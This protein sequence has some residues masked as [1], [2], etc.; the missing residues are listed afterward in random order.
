MSLAWQYLLIFLGVAVEGP[1]V[2]LTAAALAGNGLLNPWLVFLTAG[3]GNVVGDMFWYTLGYH[4]GFERRLRAWSFVAR[5]AS[6]IEQIK[7]EVNQ[8]APQL[9][10]GAKLSLGIGSIPTLIA[11]G[12]ARV[13]WWRV[14]LV[15][16]AGEIIWTGSLVLI[17]FF[18]GQYVPQILKDMRIATIVGGIIFLLLVLGLWR[19]PCYTSTKPNCKKKDV[20]N[21]NSADRTGIL[22][23]R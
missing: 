9:L 16:S 19:R 7:L 18:L 11:A 21:E 2:T 8:R 4:G 5:Y 17:G 15:Q 22:S 13:R 6:Q 20:G 12:M 10:L 23:L 1:I 14:A 3:T